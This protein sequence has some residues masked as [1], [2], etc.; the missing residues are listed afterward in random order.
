[1]ET[2]RT[3]R[4]IVDKAG[5][6]LDRYISQT[7]AELTRSYIQKLIEERRVTINSKAVKPSHKPKVGDV[8]IINVPP[9]S[10]SP[11]LI[12]QEI[13]LSIIYEDNDLMVVDK[14]S[15][16]TV[17]P[18]PGHPSCTL[19]NAI[20]AHCPD[21]S[22]I[23]SSV[24][25]GIVHRLDK[26]TS[27]LMVVAKNKAAQLN[28]AAQLK[29]RTILKKYLVLVKGRPSPEEGV[30]EAPIGRHPKDR[31]RM[32]VVPQ[33]REAR[34]SYRVMRHFKGYSLLEVTPHTGRTHQIRVHF[35]TIGCPVAGDPFY[36]VRSPYLKRQFL[37]AFLL[38]FKLPSTGEYAEF[39]SELPA[40]LQQVLERLSLDDRV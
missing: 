31:K 26:D 3:I 24:R 2:A 8:I 36:G 15:D 32:A 1:M 11:A 29:R 12:P 22:T 10:P 40:E 21:I 20:L 27:G 13:P 39:K 7:C 16:M 4:L 23:D 9:P 17:Y 35:S 38:G 6:R 30:I 28:L 18:A 5:L 34:T 33:G 19:M 25:P 37:H 14:P